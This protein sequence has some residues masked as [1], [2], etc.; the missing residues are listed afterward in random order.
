MIRLKRCSSSRVAERYDAD[1]MQDA[2]EPEL[3]PTGLRKT[4]LEFLI[5]ACGTFGSSADIYMVLRSFNTSQLEADGPD[6]IGHHTRVS[7]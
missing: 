4:H 3:Y 1:M 7:S 5:R 2:I 6:R